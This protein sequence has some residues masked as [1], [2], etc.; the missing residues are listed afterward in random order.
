MDI[1]RNFKVESEKIKEINEKR[2]AFWRD[3]L[4]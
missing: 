4:R 2:I 1:K 3:E